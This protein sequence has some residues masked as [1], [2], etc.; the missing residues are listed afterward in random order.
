VEAAG[1]LDLNAVTRVMRSRHFDTVLGRIGFNVNGDVTG[2]DPWQWFVWQAD[3]TYVP[4][5]QG[6]ANK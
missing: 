6:V 4:L 2:L 5:E 3:D 1:A